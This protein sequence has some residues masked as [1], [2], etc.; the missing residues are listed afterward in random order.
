VSENGTTAFAVEV[1][2]SNKV[3]KVTVDPQTG[4]VLKVSWPHAL[5]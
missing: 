2:V 4:N 1:A 3:Q 5:R